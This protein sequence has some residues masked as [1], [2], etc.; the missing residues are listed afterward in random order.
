ME[1]ELGH[2]D[3]NL[4]AKYLA[5]ELTAEEKQQVESWLSKEEN[6]QKF[7][8]F[9]AIWEASN[10]SDLPEVDVD[11]AWAKVQGRM[12]QKPDET[13]V[14][15]LDG[16]SQDK[17]AINWFLRIAAVLIPVIAISLA[18]WQFSNNEVQQ[19]VWESGNER[20]E[21]TLPD[22]SS[23]W[24][25]ANSKLEYSA[26]FANEIREVNLSGE[27]FFEVERNPEKPFIIHTSKAD[28]RVLGTSFNVRAFGQSTETEVV[29]ESGKVAF[30][31]EEK[32]EY[33]ELEKGDKATL[34]LKDKKIVKSESV[35]AN[36]YSRKT[37][38]L[39]FDQTEMYKVAEVLNAIFGENIQLANEEIGNCRLTATFRNQNLADIL[40]VIGETFGLRIEKADAG[41]EI[42]GAGCAAG[43]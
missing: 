28:V 33:V 1:N 20:M 37:R 11:S 35:E 34:N 27:A 43:S 14:R 25:S 3:E 19:I 41:F 13:I 22:G 42:N 21:K 38:T 36:F 6:R 24:L 4:L 32:K 5:G 29:V 8:K 40:E 30:Y 10:A 16:A 23:I 2:I 12:Q 7:K 18:V 31:T 39:V 15:K 17:P 26:E 9:K